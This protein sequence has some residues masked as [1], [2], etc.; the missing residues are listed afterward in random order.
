MKL[1][2]A[3]GWDTVRDSVNPRKPSVGASLARRCS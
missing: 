2:T 1:L 3:E